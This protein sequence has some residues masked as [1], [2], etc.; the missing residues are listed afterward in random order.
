MKLYGIIGKPLDHSLSPKFFNA[1]FKKYRRECHYLPFQVEK[2]HLKNLIVCMK[3]VD[4]Y[5]LNVTAPYK[6]AV[7]PFMDR[8]DPAAKKC[9]AVNTIVRRK[10]RFIGYNT[11]GAGFLKALRLRRK[12]SP[13]RKKIVIL[14][15]GGAAR[16]I[17][18]ALAGAGAREIIFLS[19]HPGRARKT[20]RDLK[21]YF[22]KTKWGGEKWSR[23]HFRRAAAQT[24]LLIQTTPAF[25]QLPLQFLPKEAIVCDVIYHPRRTPLLKQA[26]RRRLKILEGRWMFDYQAEANWKLW[27]GKKGWKVTL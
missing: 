7:V 26:S 24:D 10:H 5:G 22:R 25:V 12:I 3:L 19:R 17:A 14:G 27:M 8:L 6:E 13:A 4:V 16:G 21:K 15:A 23:S 20:A 11:D 9:G 1:L 18:G 2:P